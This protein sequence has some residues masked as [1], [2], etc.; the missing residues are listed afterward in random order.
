M[1]GHEGDA[2]HRRSAQS[3]DEAARILGLYYRAL[4]GRKVALV[5]CGPSQQSHDSDHTVWL[6]ETVARFG[7]ASANF[8]WCKVALTHRAA[9]HEGGTFD[10]RFHREARHYARQRPRLVQVARTGHE[11]DLELFFR[12]FEQRDLAVELFT[13]CEDLR[14]DEWS[15]RRY[16]GL[17]SAYERVQRAALLERRDFAQLRPRD[18]LAEYLVRVTLG[19]DTLPPLD[20]RLQE[21]ARRLRAALSPLREPDAT[22]EDSAEAAWR[23]YRGLTALAGAEGGEVLPTIFT[24]GYRD[25]LWTSYG[26]DHGLDPQATY[27][28]SDPRRRAGARRAALTDIDH[29]EGPPLSREPVEHDDAD[30]LA[31]HPDPGRS[32]EL[33]ADEVSSFVYPEWDHVRRAYRRNWCR[34]RETRI[35]PG[36]STRYFD[37]TLQAYGTLVPE[38][39]RHIERLTRDALRKVR[40]VPHGDELDLDAAIEAR[41]DLRAGL[42]PSE[43]V[44]ISRRKLARDVTAAFLVDVSSSTGEQVNIAGA[45]AASPI[46]Q[47]ARTLHGRNYRTIIDLEKE[48]VALL[49]TALERIGDAYGIYC[50]SGAGR[51]HVEFM[52]MKDLDERL[53]DRVTA[54][55]AAIAPR[56]TTRMGPA[57]RHA[58]RKLRSNEARTRLLVLISDGR[59]FDLDY[60]QEYGD[61][62]EVEYAVRDTREALDEARARGIQTFVLT[63]DPQG[64]D[65]LRTMCHGI[66]YE[67]LDDVNQ[68]PSRLLALYRG[69][70]GA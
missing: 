31:Q 54:R 49:M 60:G 37:E 56:Q 29:D 11:S 44:Y 65:Y 55:L 52:V 27:R 34:V 16:A 23:A 40:R 69:L 58:T 1:R 45:A 48:T 46:A 8:A 20:A 50:F 32:G 12:Q 38:I 59:P 30:D 63:I 57:I 14:L 7:E 13:L 33:D 36:S 28:F 42:S 17:R 51:E 21:T 68:L 53:S 61:N 19:D 67:V 47:R 15:K 43:Q 5:S 24:V 70:T 9:H 22:V 66:D 18:A 25:R 41:V 35:A 62:A 64:N 26:R 4:C 6:P 3:L 2:R 39:R 10:F